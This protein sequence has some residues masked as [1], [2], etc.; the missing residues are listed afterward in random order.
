V[1]F[2]ASS[3]DDPV[4][5]PN[6]FQPL[7]TPP[8]PRPGFE[9]LAEMGTSPSGPRTIW[10]TVAIPGSP[11]APA[12]PVRNAVDDGWLK[13]EQLLDSLVGDADLAMQMEALGVEAP[14]ASTNAKPGANAGGKK[15]KKQ[16][17]TLMSTGGRRGG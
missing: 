1:R 13:D 2:G 10:G 6:D 12:M 11:E 8:N 17:I 7:G 16:K 5:D 15:K 3:T 9:H 14:A 4:V